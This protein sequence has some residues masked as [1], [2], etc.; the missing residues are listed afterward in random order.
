MTHPN[1]YITRQAKRLT[2]GEINRRRFVMSALSA[3]VTM[4]TALSLASKAEASV[5]KRG[6]TLRIATTEGRAL[7]G[8]G[9]L[10]TRDAFGRLMAFTCANTLTE[11]LPD[12]QLAGE[13]AEAF[14]T[15]DAGRTWVFD[16]RRDVTFHD[17]QP[18]TAEDVV[19]TLS[20]QGPGPV[21]MSDIRAEGPHRVVVTLAEPDP[22]F[23]RKL[24]DPRH[25]ILP[26]S[27]D[28]LTATGPYRLE[29][30][31]EDGRALFTRSE[32]Y[33]KPGRAHVD[34][35]ELIPLPNISARQT[36]I[37]AG[38]VDYA[39]GIDPRALALLQH[40]PNVEILEVSAGRHIALS[41]DRI[42][43]ADI[44]S[45]LDDLRGRLPYQALVDQVLLGHGAPGNTT[46]TAPARALS[47]PLHIAVHDAG[48]PRTLE[49][50]LLIAD[51]LSCDGVPVE[52][53]SP[54]EAPAHLN[55]GWRRCD[56]A[57]DTPAEDAV[58]ALWANDISAHSAAL[59]HDGAVA[60]NFENDGARLAERWW[61]T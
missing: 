25:V 9:L 19:A 29:H 45:L 42:P 41:P 20:R 38:D 33:W 23:A 39:D 4:P 58:V 57:S 46:A 50:A 14:G 49:A 37:M 17:G 55:I 3:G 35:V 21:P 40:A 24:S 22:R 27:G 10:H 54:G 6:G 15:L 16:L 47:T 61:L 28:P 13:L 31:A 11:V 12:G 34:R 48:V 60:T 1:G 36:A 51:H 2:N 56:I 59:A 52:L 30:I 53:L 44:A 7:S 26:A 18:L 32:R 8:P 5:P 43:E